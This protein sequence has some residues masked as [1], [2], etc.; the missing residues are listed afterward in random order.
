MQ[1][2]LAA[3]HLETSAGTISSYT[4]ISNNDLD[5]PNAGLV[6]VQGHLQSMGVQV[7]WWRLR[8]SVAMYN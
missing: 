1:L 2:V 8:Q 6:I 3:P 7:Q 5:A 4:D